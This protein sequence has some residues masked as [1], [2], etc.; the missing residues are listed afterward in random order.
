MKSNYPRASD[1]TTEPPKPKIWPYSFGLGIVAAGVIWLTF[2]IML[3]SGEVGMPTVVELAIPVIVVGLIGLYLSHKTLRWS[4]TDK[5]RLILNTS[6]GS[7]IWM[8]LVMVYFGQLIPTEELMGMI[9]ASFVA[10][11][12]ALTTYLGAGWLFLHCIRWI[13]MERFGFVPANQDPFSTQLVSGATQ[14]K[15]IEPESVKVNA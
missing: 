6:V 11:L 9:A 10:C 14:A 3:L 8:S 15:A 5:K 1:A 12:I 13:A 4:R 7:W 2:L